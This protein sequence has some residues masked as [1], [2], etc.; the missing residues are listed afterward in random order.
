MDNKKTKKELFTEVLKMVESNAE[1]KQFIEK[2]I[3]LVTKKNATKSKADVAKELENARI[4]AK[5]KEE[6]KQVPFKVSAAA[7]VV[8]VTSQKLTALLQKCVK[9]NEAIREVEKSEVTYRFL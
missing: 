8:E 3:D 1:L 9:A 5:L 4:I 2:E 7:K 6:M